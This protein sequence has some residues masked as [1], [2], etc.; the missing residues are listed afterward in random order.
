MRRL[1]NPN[2]VS[3]VPKSHT[4]KSNGH[5]IPW[6]SVRHPFDYFVNEVNAYYAGNSRTGPT[7]DQLQ[8]ELCAQL[9]KWN[10]TGDP[11]Y[12]TSS[13]AMA[14][15]THRSGGCSSCGKKR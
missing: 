15:A 7:I 5:K 10:C 8:E 2:H 4:D 3:A 14:S 13:R 9:P 12:H 1:I 11:H 6:D